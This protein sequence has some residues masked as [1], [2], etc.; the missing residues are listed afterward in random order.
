VDVHKLSHFPQAQGRMDDLPLK[1]QPD[2]FG[3]DIESSFS[4]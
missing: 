1:K 3:L 4:S 2:S